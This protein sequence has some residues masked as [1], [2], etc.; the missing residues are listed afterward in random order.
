MLAK[1]YSGA[2]SGVDARTVEIEVYIQI[3]TSQFAIVGLPDTAVK[4][5]KD[6]IPKALKSQG[7]A[8]KKE[9]DVTVN[10]APADVK[11]E[12]P[13]YDLPIAVCLLKATGAVKNNRLDE[14]GMIGELALSGEVR[15]VRGILPMVIEMRR[16]GMRAVLCRRATSRRRASCREST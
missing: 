3:G 13:I 7:L 2:I 6:R 11:K 9:Y 16:I 14:Y 5:A 15:R 8:P 1:C 10:L 4:E 12:G